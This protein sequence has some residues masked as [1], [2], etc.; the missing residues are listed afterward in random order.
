MS[1]SDGFYSAFMTGADGQ[2]Y[3]LLVFRE[4]NIIGA[5]PLGVTFDGTFGPEPNGDG[6]S[7]EVHVK[8]PAGGTLIQGVSTGPSGLSYSVPIR[9]PVDFA[10][11]PF[12]H[13]E[14]PLGPVNVKLTKIRGVEGL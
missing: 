11:R 6:W 12:I 1:F 3:A 7:G 5:D 14:T 8:A 2:G 10:E 13:I 9:L 4:G